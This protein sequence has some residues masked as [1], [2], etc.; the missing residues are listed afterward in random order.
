MIPVPRGFDDAETSLEPS[1]PLGEE[2]EL[3]VREAHLFGEGFHG[4]VDVGD[5]LFETFL[6]VTPFVHEH[7]LSGRAGGDEAGMSRYSLPP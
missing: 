4:P 3:I 6:T 2:R 1:D 7:T 5:H